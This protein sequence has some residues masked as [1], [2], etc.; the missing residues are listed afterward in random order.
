M[1]ELRGFKFVATSVLVFKKIGTDDKT[2][3]ND[4]KQLLMK[5]TLMMYLNQYYS[6]IKNTKIFSEMF[7]LDFGLPPLARI[8]YINLIKELDHP[9]KDWPFEILMIINPL[10]GV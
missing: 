10:N 1:T 4:W 8:S 6:Y 3:Y 7:R 5:V 9:K 2:K